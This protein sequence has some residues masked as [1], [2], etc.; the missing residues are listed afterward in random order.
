MVTT[1]ATEILQDNLAI[2]IARALT[3][4]N[5]KAQELGVDRLQSRISI[6][7]HSLMGILFGELVI[8]PKII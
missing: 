1:L 7:Q 4:A 2:S 3:V 6:I 5:K 8:F